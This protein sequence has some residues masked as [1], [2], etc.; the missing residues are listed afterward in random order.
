MSIAPRHALSS[1]LPRVVID[2]LASGRPLAAPELREAAGAV[3]LSDI[4][5]FTTLVEDFAARGRAG[6]EELTWIL[7]S[8]VGDVVDAVEGH[9]GDILSIAGDAF[10]CYWPTSTDVDLQLAVMRATQAAASIQRA[11][12][13]RPAGDS[14][15]FETRIG[16][17]TGDLLLAYV[18][19]LGGRWE[20]IASGDALRD[21]VRV[22]RTAIP[23]RVQLSAAAWPYAAARCNGR[24]T[25]N[26][27]ELENILDPLPPVPHSIRPDLDEADTAL[28]AFV[29]P[30]VLD[31]L[32]APDAEWLAESRAVTVTLAAVPGLTS[33]T[34]IELTRTHDCIRA[35]QEIVQRFE[36]TARVD[37]DEKG[38]LLLAVF[39][40]PPRFHEDDAVRGVLAASELQAVFARAHLERGVGITTGRALCG[41]FGNDRRRDYMVR[42]DVIN[43]AARLMH[44]EPSG[45][46][47]DAATV[48]AVRGRLTFD[49]L[50]PLRV[51]GRADPVQVFRPGG[52]VQRS[53]PRGTRVIGRQCE[54]N[55]LAARLD[56]ARSGGHAGL[57][58]IEADA[59]LG[60][61]KLVNELSRQAAAADVRVLTAVADAI[62]RSTAYYAWRPVLAAMFGLTPDEDTSMARH[63]VLQEMA[64]LPDIER[65]APLL[66]SVLPV[67]IPDSPLTAEMTGD[68]RADNTKR[69]LRRLLERY[70]TGGQ[71]LLVVEDAHWLDS[72]SWGLL[73]DAVS[74]V[75]PLMT[76]V[77][78]RPLGEPA[79]PDFAQLVR[80]A[81]EHVLR[82]EALSGDETRALIAERVGVAEVP[83]ALAAFVD[84][85]VAGH[86]FFCEEL[87]RAMLE[88]AVV[89]VSDGVCAVGDLA[90]VDL[91]TTVEGVIVS[92]LDRLTPAQQL[93]LKVASVIGR[94]FRERMVRETHPVDSQRDAVRGHLA[95]LA[96]LDLTALEAPEPDLAY[97]FKHVITRDVTYESMPF[98]QRQPLHRA[99]A[100]WYERT[101]ASDLGP[102]YALLAYHWAR[103]ANP[104]RTIDYLEKAGEQAL[105]AGA[106]REAVLF[107][108]QAI[109]LIESGDISVEPTRR[110]LWEKGLG[111][112]HYYLGALDVSRQHN[113]RALVALH[114]P[115]P[116]TSA[117]AAAGAIAGIARQVGHR[118]FPR[119]YLGKRAGE[120][121]L[122]DEAVECYKI[123]GQ[124]YYLE[125]EPPLKL[126][127]LTV[128]GLN[129]G[130]EAGPSPAL[131]RVIINASILAY[132]VGQPAQAEW[133]AARAIEM[134]EREG[135]SASAYVW[136]IRALG[137]AQRAAWADAKAANAKALTLTRELGD[138]G[139]EAE[140]W[141]VR[142][143]IAV[144]EGDFAFAPTGWMRQ[145]ELAER[146]G[147]AKLKCW[148]LLDE[149]D[150]WL[151]RGDV[152]KAATA[153]DAALAIGTAASDIG[154][155]LDKARSTA[156]T[157]LRQGRDEDAARAADSIFDLLRRQPPTGYQW[158]DD[159][160]EAVEVYITLLGRDGQYVQAHRRDLESRAV[161]GCKLAL[162]FSR[163]YRNVSPRAWLLRG[164]LKR[165]QGKH[166]EARR[167]FERAASIGAA[168]D[169]PFERARAQLELTGTTDGGDRTRLAV[170]A[171]AVFERLGATYFARLLDTT[172]GVNGGPPT[173]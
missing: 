156:V 49:A 153:L 42:G 25:E 46:V 44:V 121:A 103:A 53:A 14:R 28:R 170:E 173:T 158:A 45:S 4:K 26:G 62:E 87:L 69:L 32:V 127:Y 38:A 136:H 56:V 166:Q 125:G 71:T 128:T 96:A 65:L 39:G 52:R 135:L 161:A 108:T 130:E 140:G 171:R 97:L 50:E 134:A 6:L 147:N 83:D 115:V 48:H 21:A 30:A 116:R 11:V 160:C 33:A 104:S 74:S 10:L 81:G 51:P 138:F 101:Y 157:R 75:R 37:V 34:A 12:H 122:L 168:L 162:R 86:P 64:D 117:R 17:G 100:A 167:A 91:P 107:L 123:L 118:L 113:E 36:G 92:R 112:A 43:L 20:L 126:L 165:H 111:R 133:Y 144:C 105:Y 172:P 9:G 68:V 2:R 57:T 54:L 90:A 151:G 19:G 22:E 47:C 164:Q 106:F 94:A 79:P 7:N 88:A 93:C 110:A 89:Q 5:G 13:D 159:F 3:L 73:L 76:V 40:L 155:T 131:A 154:T 1:Y 58:I 109:K 129:I 169:M 152:D 143:T 114:R 41:A 98:V 137:L 18:G 72:V 95:A 55:D 132:L 61:S 80:L 102:L 16:V 78:T 77:A 63:R 82:L 23:G 119:R 29:P 15:K 148:S 142:T 24:P 66:S 146:N 85:R 163:I 8:Y 84:A 99:V 139:L 60:K 150:T 67:Q 149:T 35:F 120:K 27:V 59:G 141:T 145:R 124:A 31:R 70:V